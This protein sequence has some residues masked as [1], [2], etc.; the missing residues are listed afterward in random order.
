MTPEVGRSFPAAAV[1]VAIGILTW[2]GYETTKACLESLRILED[3]PIPTV[4]I[5]NG[6]GTGEGRRLA[7]EFGEP[8][9]TVEMD[10]DGGVPVGYNAAVRW[11]SAKQAEH[12]LLL[13]NDTVITDPAMLRRL[14]QAAGPG[15]GVVGPLILDP[16]GSTFSA[17]GALS[18]TKGY[19]EHHKAPIDP[20]RP[21]DADWLDGPA[22]LMSLAAARAIGALAPEYFMYWEELDWCVRARRAGY[23]SVVQPS[24]SIT[25]M[26][27]TATE[28]DFV[29][30]QLAR[31]R[32]LFLRRNASAVENLTAQFW[33]SASLIRRLGPM[34]RARAFVRAS[35]WNLRDA[36]RRRRWRLP[37]D[38][39]T[40]GH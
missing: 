18:M 3:W 30:Y 28:S 38:G 12:V 26:R 9:E 37:A 25:H 11:A 19:S 6:S 21:Y 22:M 31:N 10:S 13:N 8:V 33:M 32:I 15:I 4:V 34:P 7:E 36:V 35:L 20:D 23:R 29:R 16:D 14:L 2:R 17:G 24:T 5:D 39:P 40:I 1:P 27:G